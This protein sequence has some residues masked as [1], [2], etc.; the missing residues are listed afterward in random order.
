MEKI[1]IVKICNA[2]QDRAELAEW[3]QLNDWGISWMTE[4]EADALR[5]AYAHRN[6]PH[7]VKVEHCP[8]V[9]RF[10]VT[11]FKAQRNN[12]LKVPGR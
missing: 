7:G 8:N 9:N 11:V 12:L 6:A 4:T 5:I 3:P 2:A 1:N 10:M